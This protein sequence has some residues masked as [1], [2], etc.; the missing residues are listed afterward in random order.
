MLT[1]CGYYKKVARCSTTSGFAPVLMIMR[2]PFKRR[3]APFRST[4][5]AM[6]IQPEVLRFVMASMKRDAI[7][8]H[9]RAR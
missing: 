3:R 2:S 6:P 1:T 7:L 4:I 5:N 8:R 9:P